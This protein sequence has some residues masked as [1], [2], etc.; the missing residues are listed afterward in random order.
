MMTGLIIMNALGKVQE[1]NFKKFMAEADDLV[2][3]DRPYARMQTSRFRPA[4]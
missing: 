1:R 2:V 4:P 3:I